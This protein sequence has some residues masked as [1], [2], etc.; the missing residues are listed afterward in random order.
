[1]LQGSNMGGIIRPTHTNT[2]SLSPS[3]RNPFVAGI[4]DMS[5]P[6][7]WNGVTLDKY[8]GTTDPYEHIYIYVAQVG[9]YIMDDVVV[10][11]VFHTS[12]K[13]QALSWF[14]RI[15]AN[16]IDCFETLTTIFPIYK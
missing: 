5:S 9:L 1:M 10:C 16:S 2:T 4:I 15:S 7:T 11:K 13:G 6:P 14:T 12:L 3:P 8:D